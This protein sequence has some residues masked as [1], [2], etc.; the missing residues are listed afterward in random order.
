MSHFTSGTNYLE[1]PWW[2]GRSR[3]DIRTIIGER[4]SQGATR[5]RRE[6]TGR[7]VKRQAV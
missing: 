2:L 1:G 6:D 4:F 7:R 3:R 5:G